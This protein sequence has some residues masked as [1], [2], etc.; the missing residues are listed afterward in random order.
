[1]APNFKTGG[2][3][4]GTPNKP[5]PIILASTEE[6]RELLAMA[7]VMRTPKAVMLEAMLRFA[8][9]VVF[10]QMRQPSGRQ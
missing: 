2:R 1:M 6:N 10:L 9:T 5:R 3:T 4:K 7:A 8:D